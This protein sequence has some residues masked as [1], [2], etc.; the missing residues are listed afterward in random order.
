[1]NGPFCLVSS[2]GSIGSFGTSK[3]G[4]FSSSPWAGSGNVVPLGKTRPGAPGVRGLG[5]VRGT[6]REDRRLWRRASGGGR[7]RSDPRRNWQPACRE[8]PLRRSAFSWRIP[9]LVGSSGVETGRATWRPRGPL[10]PRA[11]SVP[12]AGRVSPSPGGK[13]ARQNTAGTLAELP[14]LAQSDW[15]DPQVLEQSWLQVDRDRMTGPRAAGL[16]FSSGERIGW[17]GVV[18]EAKVPALERR[19]RRAARRS[20]HRGPNGRSRC[21]PARSPGAGRRA[22]H[23]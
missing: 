21:S 3:V 9:F 22:T 11:G 5:C 13:T 23:R 8:V 17:E 15:P 7:A 16:G 2:Q 1:M 6:G 14:G 10:G 20:R 18:E 12:S 19:A 4:G